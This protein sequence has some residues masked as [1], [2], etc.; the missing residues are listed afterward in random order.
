[1]FQDDGCDTL[2]KYIYGVHWN[3]LKLHHWLCGLILLSAHSS[4]DHHLNTDISV[5]IHAAS[6]VLITWVI[7]QEKSCY[8]LHKTLFLC[9]TLQLSA[10]PSCGI[11]AKMASFS[12]HSTLGPYTLIVTGIVVNCMQAF[13]SLPRY[14][15]YNQYFLRYVIIFYIVC[16]HVCI[17]IELYGLF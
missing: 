7:T 15:N 16:S 5:S 14:N 17:C 12:I 6:F 3:A 2:L 10:S 8:M 9:T 4:L 1:M 13:A 11:L